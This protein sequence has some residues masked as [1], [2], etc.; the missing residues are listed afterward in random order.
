MRSIES[1]RLAYSGI[2]FGITIPGAIRH[3]QQMETEPLNPNTLTPPLI[4][5]VA[6]VMSASS[7]DDMPMSKLHKLFRVMANQLP[8]NIRNLAILYGPPSVTGFLIAS[9]K[10]KF[11]D[12]ATATTQPDQIK[13]SSEPILTAKVNPL[14][15]ERRAKAHLN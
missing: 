10:K 15:S 6:T 4:G 1:T 13:Q 11:S 5:L 3:F 2:I 8:N 9:A 12:K 14:S 7:I